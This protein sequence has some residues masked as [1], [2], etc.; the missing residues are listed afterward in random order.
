[1]YMRTISAIIL[2]IFSVLQTKAQLHLGAKAGANM[3]KIAGA[4]FDENYKL[5]YQLGGF[6][7]YDMSKSTAV[8]IEVLFSQT[9][10]KVSQR[11]TDVLTDAFDRGKKMNYVSVPILLRLNTNGLVSI[12]GG[13]QFSF[14]SD[15][16]ETL[17]NNSKKLFNNTDFGLIAGTEI[18]L[19]PIRVYARYV[20]GFSNISNMGGKAESRQIQAGLAFRLF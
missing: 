15:G 18:N 5:G 4:S 7:A 14:L 10:T 9:N 6:I 16:N 2:I 1:M 17:L 19:R 3:T 13:S 8:H 11:Y 20:W 12:M